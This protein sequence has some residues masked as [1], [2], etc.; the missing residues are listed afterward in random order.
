MSKH[1]NLAGSHLCLPWRRRRRAGVADET[2]HGV[3]ARGRR[4]RSRG[5]RW[6]CGAV[7]AASRRFSAP[8][9]D[10]IRV[11]TMGIVAAT[12]LVTSAAV[13]TS[14]IYSTARRGPTSHL[15]GWASPIRTR[16]KGPVRRWANWWRSILTFSP[17]IS[18]YTFKLLNLNLTLY[19]SLLALLS[20]L[21]SLQIGT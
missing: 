20:V 14:S 12:N 19:F 10:W 11:R 3:G 15:L 21:I 4:T 5:G 2:P 17:L 18:P 7:A 16:V 6:R 1:F 13:P 8:S 9:L